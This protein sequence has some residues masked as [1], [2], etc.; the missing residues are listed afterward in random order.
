MHQRR[1]VSYLTLRPLS[2]LLL[3]KFLSPLSLC[4]GIQMF[5]S[6]L[7]KASPVGSN[8]NRASAHRFGIVWAW[9]SSCGWWDQEGLCGC[10]CQDFCWGSVYTHMW[11]CVHVCAHACMYRRVWC[12][13]ELLITS[14]TTN[15]GLRVI[16]KNYFVMNILNIKKI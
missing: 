6:K 16:V 15:R 7:L 13:S 1:S 9:E 5:F 14:S 12:F 2:C 11:R 3:T 8:H 10:D 4:F